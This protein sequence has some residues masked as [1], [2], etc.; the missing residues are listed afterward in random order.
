MSVP[1]DDIAAPVLLG[2]IVL[3]AETILTEAHDMGISQADHLR[4]LIV[5]GLLHLL[6]FDHIEA[7]E[8]EE[9]EALEIEILA[10]MGIADPYAGSDP[11]DAPA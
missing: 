1:D 9:M 4:H 8:A 5:H 6:G 10:T 11:A 7:E 3:A 2:D